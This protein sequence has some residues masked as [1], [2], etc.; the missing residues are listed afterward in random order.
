MNISY[1]NSKM[2]KF[3]YFFQTTHNKLYGHDEKNIDVLYN[4]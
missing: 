2:P 4:K 3:I 1:V